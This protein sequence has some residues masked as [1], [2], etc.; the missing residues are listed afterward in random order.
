MIGPVGFFD[1]GIGGRSVLDAFRRIAPGERTVY[2]A[3]TEN[4]PYGNRPEP[5]IKRLAS[6]CAQK[7]IAMGCPLVVV[8][9]N[10]ASAAALEHLRK[11]FPDTSFVG[12]EPA[13][14]P[15]LERTKT[16]K[17]AVLATRGTFNGKLYRNTLG[18]LQG[19]V[20][21]IEEVADEF[22]ELVE[23]GDTSGPNAEKIVAG[24]IEPLLRAGVDQIVLG[25][26]H[27]PHLKS[28][29]E[30]IAAGRAEVVDPSA[31]VAERARNILE[32]IRKQGK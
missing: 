32:Q 5:E 24:K 26:T 30:K 3:D 29:I 11:T 9:C 8:A 10:T 22:V 16:K 25:C 2:L 28:V 7:L 20:T 19:D 15:A 18:R 31:A 6:A 27:F 4:C 14:K 17:I 21:V 12:M 1:S 13:V 23:A